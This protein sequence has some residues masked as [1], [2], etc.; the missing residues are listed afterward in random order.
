MRLQRAL[1]AFVLCVAFPIPLTAQR[2]FNVGHEENGRV[3]VQVNATLDDGRGDSKPLG[4]L[5]LTLYLSATD[6]M[7]V[8]TDEAGVLKF[9]IPAGKYRVASD[10]PVSWQGRLYRWNLPIVVR[11]RMEIV[12]LTAENATTSGM[13]PAGTRLAQPTRSSQGVTWG[14]VVTAP[15]AEHSGALST[16]PRA[17]RGTAQTA[18]RSSEPASAVKWGRVV[19]PASTDSSAQTKPPAS[20]Q[21]TQ[22]SAAAQPAAPATPSSPRVKWGR[23][24]KPAGG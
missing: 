13:G 21:P 22:A 15:T 3:Y 16:V 23:V 14:H 8:R 18:P 11:P 19:T 20:S 4:L 12:E 9:A 1:A 17:T 7:R 6:S 5:L 24:V 2:F 10:E